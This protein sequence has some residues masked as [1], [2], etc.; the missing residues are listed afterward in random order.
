M[1]AANNQAP[2]KRRVT[3]PHGLNLRKSASLKAPV[4]AVM[5]C[6]ATVDVLG[7]GGGKGWLKV[8]YPT[9]TEVLEGWCRAEYTKA[10]ADDGTDE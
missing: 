2:G 5:P 6:G 8:R 3:W 4:L 10:V 1:A 9:P 7:T